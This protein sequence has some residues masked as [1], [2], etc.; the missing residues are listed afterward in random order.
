MRRILQAVVAGAAAATLVSTTAQAQAA[1]IVLGGGA[2]V[3]IGDYG[4]YAKTGWMGV[5]GVVVPIGDQGLFV[6]G[7]FLYGSNKH[8][9][10]TGDK[11]NLYGGLAG[12]GY[13]VGDRSKPGV[14]FFGLAGG[15]NHQYK[16]GSSTESSSNEWKFAF[17]G[18]GGF[19]IPVGKAS[20]WVQGRIISRSDTKF[21]PIL[22][23]ITIP[24]GGN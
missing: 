9:D 10:G 19:D 2:T 6:G 17:G 22:A 16:P 4:D 13:R 8:D 7:E 5:G 12:L 18:G 11:T 14:F 3:P 20:I 21:I 1:A 24:V 15:L 23:G